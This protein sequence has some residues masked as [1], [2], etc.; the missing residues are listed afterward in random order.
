MSAEM[1]APRPDIYI[2]P[3]RD[4]AGNPTLMLAKVL[5]RGG[6]DISIVR[7]SPRE[8]VFNIYVHSEQARQ[9]FW[10]IARD[11]D[12]QVIDRAM[13]GNPT[14]QPDLAHCSFDKNAK[15]KINALYFS[16]LAKMF[17]EWAREYKEHPSLAQIWAKSE[18]ECQEKMGGRKPLSVQMA[19]K[20]IIRVVDRTLATS[21]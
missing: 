14:Y 5:I 11:C 9:I 6:L 18:E 17:G 8:K 1:L 12:Y 19:R 21:D 7:P 4:Y 3:A 10:D 16:K 20:L 15:A 13:R 2:S